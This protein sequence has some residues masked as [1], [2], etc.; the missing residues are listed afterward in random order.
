MTTSEAFNYFINEAK[1][2]GYTYAEVFAFSDEVYERLN[3]MED[4]SVQAVDILI[5]EIL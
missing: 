2:M 4:T 5:E 1:Q 3:L